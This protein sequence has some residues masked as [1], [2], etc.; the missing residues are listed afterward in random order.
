MPHSAPLHELLKHRRVLLL[1]GPMGPFFSRLAR[2]LGRSGAQVYKVNFNG[3]DQLF[4]RG[5]SAINYRGRHDDWGDWLASL[6]TV[7]RIDAIVLFGQNR[8]VHQVAREVAQARGLAVYVFEEGYV[9]PDFVTLERGGVN[10]YS[11]LPRDPAFY[12]ACPDEPAP[13]PAP[14]GQTF[15]RTAGLAVAYCLA[16]MVAQPWYRGHVY[17]RSMHPLRQALCWVRSGWRKL[18]YG[19]QQR[20]VLGELCSPQRSKRW[21]LLPLQVHNDSQIVHHSAFDDVHD[22]IRHVMTSF[23]Q[24]ADPDH[25]LVIKHHPMDR[26]Y[27]DY[28]ECIAGLARELGI[29]SRVYYVHDLHLPT[30][31]KHTL[32]VVTVNSTTGL[33]A[34]THHAPVIT[35]GDCFYAVPGLVHAGPLSEF[36]RAP[37][38]VNE[39]LFRRFR[40]YLIRHTQVNASFYAATPALDAPALRVADTAGEVLP[41]ADFQRSMPSQPLFADELPG[42]LQIQPQPPTAAA[43]GVPSGAMNDAGFVPAL[44]A[45]PGAGHAPTTHP[46][47]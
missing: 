23:A 45:A 14:T 33:Q 34:M 4:Y 46:R 28:G 25:A 11:S 36:W 16:M 32:G 39:E 10:G 9:R 22:V 24:H 26:A 41:A 15:W 47:A 17:H 2:F 12:A 38:E 1:Q 40:T 21:F 43:L 19:W 7:K 31:L 44:H 3:G 37:G 35:L 8:P 27:V 30:L 5:P 6:L 18:T 42:A 29:A 13:R 20:H